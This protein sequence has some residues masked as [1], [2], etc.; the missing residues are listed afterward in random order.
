MYELMKLK[1]QLSDLELELFRVYRE[2]NRHKMRLIFSDIK[3]TKKTIQ[4]LQNIG[5]SMDRE[6]GVTCGH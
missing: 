4:T 6:G 5:A 3:A 2:K 1:K